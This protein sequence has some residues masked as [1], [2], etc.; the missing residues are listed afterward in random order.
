MQTQ[1]EALSERVVDTADA[2]VKHMQHMHV[3][4]SSDMDEAGTVLYISNADKI[5]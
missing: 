3:V 4:E 2:A 1:K 5:W